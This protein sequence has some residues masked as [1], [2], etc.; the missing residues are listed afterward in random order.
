MDKTSRR[1]LFTL[2]GGAAAMAAAVGPASAA[3]TPVVEW[4]AHMFSAN[5][6]RFPFHPKATYKPD[7]TTVSSRSADSLSAAHEAVR[8]RQGGGGAARTLWR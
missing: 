1:E 2:M 4:N 6:A 7:A 5:T 8:N 3:A